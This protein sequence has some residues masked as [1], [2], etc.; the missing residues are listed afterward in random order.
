MKIDHHDQYRKINNN[1]DN[2]NCAKQFTSCNI[3]NLGVF[4]PTELNVP[5]S[6]CSD[7]N[8]QRFYF[9][10]CNYSLKNHATI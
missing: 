9:I 4:V 6:K 5:F 8:H 2:N 1:T 7:Y 3:N 10:K